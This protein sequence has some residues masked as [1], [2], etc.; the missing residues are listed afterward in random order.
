MGIKFAKLLIFPEDCEFYNILYIKYDRNYA[1][2][3]K[4]N[5]LGIICYKQGNS[6]DKQKVRVKDWLTTVFYIS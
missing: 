1:L 6:G 4:Y 3:W 2:M 5:F